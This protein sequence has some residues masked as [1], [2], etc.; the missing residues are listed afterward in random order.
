MNGKT[1]NDLVKLDGTTETLKCEQL[2]LKLGR[3]IKR[4]RQIKKI[5][6]KDL[7]TVS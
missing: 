3:F 4:G 2:P 6:Q 5:T 7:A 1:A